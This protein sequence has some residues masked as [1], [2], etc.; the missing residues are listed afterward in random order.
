VL[1]PIYERLP[2][3]FGTADP[4]RARDLLEVLNAS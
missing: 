1:E 2:E 4:L 3:G